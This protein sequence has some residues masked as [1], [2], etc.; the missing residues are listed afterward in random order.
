[1]MGAKSM[2]ERGTKLSKLIFA[3]GI[4]F[5]TGVPDSEFRDLITE[6]EHTEMNWRYVPATREDNAIALAVGATLAGEHP[7]IFM[8][9][10]GIGNAI[11]A[12][13]SLASVYGIPLVL[14]IAWAGYQGRDIPHHNAIGEPLLQVLRALNI[15]TLEVNLGGPLECIA[16]AIGKAATQ[17]GTVN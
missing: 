11:D 9:S 7:L 17:A 2:T 15:P 16:E 5:I 10:S 4:T 1:M 3:A 6:L 8:E 14:F 12:L 13:T